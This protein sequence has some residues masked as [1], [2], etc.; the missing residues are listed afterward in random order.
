M[1]NKANDLENDLLD[2]FLNNDVDPSKDWLN[3]TVKEFIKQLEN[4]KQNHTQSCISERD[5]QRKAIIVD[6]L[7]INALLALVHGKCFFKKGEYLEY[8]AYGARTVVEQA[9]EASSQSPGSLDGCA[10]SSHAKNLDELSL[11]QEKYLIHLTTF[12]PSMLDLKKSIE[13]G[14]RKPLGEMDILS[15]RA[16]GEWQCRHIKWQA[17]AQVFWLDVKANAKEISKKLLSSVELL[18]L[19][20]LWKLPNIDKSPKEE[21]VEFRNLENV[22]RIVNPRGV[23]KGRPRKNAITPQY[24]VFIP[25]VYDVKLREINW[26]GL[27]IA[28]EIIVKVMRIQK[29]SRQEIINHPLIHQYQYLD[30]DFEF[31]TKM[32]IRSALKN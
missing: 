18:D 28:L 5:L 30:P 29:M 25:L 1:D 12:F 32:V 22:V 19:L 7:Y 10:G 24:P 14:S 13:N 3:L 15:F 21:E 31:I 9:S 20:D 4:F 16:I 8:R 23:K 26:N 6:G 27:L 11:W 2:I 17:A